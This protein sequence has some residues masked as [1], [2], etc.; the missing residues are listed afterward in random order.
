ME[1][2]KPC[3][4]CGSEAKIKSFGDPMFNERYFAIVCSDDILCGAYITFGFR[5]KTRRGTI[6]TWNRRT[7]NEQRNFI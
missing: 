3:P 1:E 4:F 2:L 7:S 5:S 6:K